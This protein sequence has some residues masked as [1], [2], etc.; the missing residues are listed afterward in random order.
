M[1]IIGHISVLFHIINQYVIIMNIIYSI[2]F[3]KMLKCWESKKKKS[4]YAQRDA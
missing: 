3:N 2:W 4:F 1:N